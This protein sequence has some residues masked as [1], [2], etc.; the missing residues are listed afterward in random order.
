MAI[1]DY[2]CMYID[3]GIKFKVNTDN[4]QYHTLKYLLVENFRSPYPI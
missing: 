2:M 1:V 3:G 4:I